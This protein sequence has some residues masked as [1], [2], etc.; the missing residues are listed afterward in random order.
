MNSQKTKSTLK[1]TKIN[2]SFPDYQNKFVITF[3]NDELSESETID[4]I[5]KFYI[6]LEYVGTDFGFL[7]THDKPN[8]VI[9]T[10]QGQNYD[11]ENET[12]QCFEV[13]IKECIQTICKKFEI[14]NNF[15][16]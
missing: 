2:F 6:W 7:I 10:Y 14:E 3:L 8:S 12:S 9:F 5:E 15:Y 1:L 4:L 16:E 13:E 11:S